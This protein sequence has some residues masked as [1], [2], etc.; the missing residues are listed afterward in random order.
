MK[1]KIIYIFSTLILLSLGGCQKLDDF[2]D[3][4]VNPAA[5]SEPTMSAL[6]AN[7]QAGLVGYAASNRPGLYGQYFCSGS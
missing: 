7:V 2:G 1:K 3:T 5:T 4:N 6:M